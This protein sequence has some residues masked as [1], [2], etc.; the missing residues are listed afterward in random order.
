MRI[1][2]F[3]AFRPAPGWTEQVAS[4]PYD[5]VTR[6]EAVRIAQGNDACF[7]RV[8]RADLELPSSV[9]PTAPE[10]Y[11]RAAANW[12]RF[13]ERGWMVQDEHPSLFLYEQS[14][15]GHVQVGLVGLYHVADY[16]AE[17]VRKHEHTRPEPEEDRARHI[18]AT[19][20]QSGPVFLA[21]RDRAGALARAAREAAD[22]LQPWFEFT[23]PD[24]V[25]HRGWRLPDASEW[26]RLVD[27]EP[28]A[29]IADGH[30]RAAAAARVARARAGGPVPSDA[31]AEWAWVL[32]VIFPAASLRI[33]PYQRCVRDLGGLSEAELLRRAQAAFELTALSGPAPAAAGEIVM[34]LR[35]G[36][37]RLRATGPRSS[38]PVESLD[39][40]IL[41]DRLLGP[42]LGITDP[43]R[44]P[45]ISFVGGPRSLEELVERLSDGRAAAV[46]AVPAV[47]IEQIMAVADAGEVMPP[48][49]TWFEPKLRSGLF[50]HAIA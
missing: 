3:R 44:D 12:R 18:S 21:V 6:E 35:R 9:S 2:P 20:I 48:K 43:R 41:Q 13:R 33:L 22:H 25:R 5:V 38:H 8:S 32:A 45:R 34:G 28:A 7:L 36:W 31:D 17:I 42:V 50:V 19:Q 1:R 26:I 24:G 30:H 47:S 10:V 23:A 4:P 11:E 37:W 46:F 40:Q 39:V 49:S 16:E 15:P 27:A 14:V 29:Y